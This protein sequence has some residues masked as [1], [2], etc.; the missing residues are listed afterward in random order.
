[1]TLQIAIAQIN[2]SVGD[3]AANAQ[4]IHQAAAKAAEKGADVLLTPELSL[5]GYPPEDLLLRSSFLRRSQQVL[6]AL[7]E[8]S[9]EFPSL[10]Y[11]VGYPR[12]VEGRVYNA[13][14][15]F[16]NGSVLGHYAK[17]ELPNYAV[18][19]EQRYFQPDGAPF[20]FEVKGVR[21]GLNICEDVWFPRAAAMAK[22]E[23]AQALLVMNASPFHLNKQNE[24]LEVVRA[25]VV[26]HK[27]PTVFCNLVGGQ[28]ELVFDGDSFAVDGEGHVTARA[29]RF[30]E[31]LC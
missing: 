23:G 19:D 27:I 17:L 24:R 11:L 5:V 25:N 20:V 2:A 4:K 15:V 9:Q 7:V 13:A 26:R 8:K 6:D 31:D 29:A 12:E 16:K 14:L 21:L 3:L 1:M 30:K 22:A 28:D 18:F 10:T